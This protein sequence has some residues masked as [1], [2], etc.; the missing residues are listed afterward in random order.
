[1]TEKI[2]FR[3]RADRSAVFLA[4]GRRG[5]VGEAIRERIRPLQVA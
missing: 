2:Y 4:S 1:M 5:S 3:N